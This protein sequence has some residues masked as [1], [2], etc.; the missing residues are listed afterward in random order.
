MKIMPLIRRITGKRK[1]PI[2]RDEYGL[3]ARKLAFKA[4]D[5]GKGPAE[6]SFELPISRRTAYRYFA[7]WKK[8]KPNLDFSYRSLKAKLKK[9]RQFSEQLIISLS[10]PLGMSREEV[11][12][13]FQKPWGIKQLIMGNWPDYARE[14][15]H[16]KQE[17]RLGAALHMINL[18]EQLGVTPDEF[19]AAFE[20]LLLEVRNEK[21]RKTDSVGESN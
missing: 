13:R 10:N 15:V 12:L 21:K 11:I 19:K 5:L 3:S 7:D 2:I 8:Q 4:F 20:R 1:Y 18:F 14:K 9:D 16:S 6:V 17:A